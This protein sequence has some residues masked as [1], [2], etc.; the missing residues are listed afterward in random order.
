MAKTADEIL[1]EVR[2]GKYQYSS[3]NK[4]TESNKNKSVVDSNLSADEILENVRAGKYK[5]KFDYSKTQEEIANAKSEIYANKT[6]EKGAIS[7]IVNQRKNNKNLAEQAAEQTV[8]NESKAT[9]YE[10]MKAQAKEQK[11]TAGNEKLASILNLVSSNITGGDTSAAIKRYEESKEPYKKAK[12]DLNT[13]KKNKWDETQE[14]NAN[15]LA[16]NADLQALVAKASAAKEAFDNSQKTFQPDSILSHQNTVKYYEEYHNLAKQIDDLGY[17]ATSLVDTYTRQKNLEET[18]EYQKQAT[19]FA[20]KH[21][22][23]SSGAYVGANALQVG[24][25]P[26]ILEAGI[27]NIATDE[28]VPIDT[29]SSG[30]LATNVRNSIA[31]ENTSNITE[32][33]YEK[34]NSELAAETSA[35]LYQT[36]LSI[37]D[38][39]SAAWMPKSMSLAIMSSSA[40]ASTA[41]EAT[42]RGLSADKAML[43]AGISAAAEIIFEKYSIDGIKYLKTLGKSGIKNVAKDILKQSFTEGSEELFTEIS[44]VVADMVIN[45]DDSALMQQYQQLID[46]GISESDAK[47]QVAIEFAKQVGLAYLGG[48]ISGSF[49]GGGVSAV[50]T[51]KTNVDYAKEGKAIKQGGFAQDVVNEGLSQDTNSKAYQAAAII[52]KNNMIESENN[53]DDVIDFSG[54]S[55]KKLGKLQ[56]LNVKAVDTQNFSEAVADESNADSLVETF[57]KIA[58]GDVVS[59]ESANELMNNEVAR[60]ALQQITGYQIESGKNN[61]D[62]LKQLSAQYRANTRTTISNAPHESQ[63][64]TLNRINNNLAVST[65]KTA[66]INPQKLTKQLDRTVQLADNTEDTIAT[67]SSVENGKVF[68]ETSNGQV[69]DVADVSFS[70]PET[71]S[72]YKSA[73]AYTEPV[74]RA[75]VFAYGNGEYNTDL[76]DYMSGVNKVWQYQKQGYSLA[77]ATQLAQESSS[78]TEMQAKMIY[79]AASQ[80]G[81]IAKSNESKQKNETKNQSF[82]I[83]KKKSNTV[84]KFEKALNSNVKPGATVVAENLQPSQKAEVELINE[85]AK[86]INREIVIVS[87]LE[88]LGYGK[89]NGIYTKGKIVLPLNAD[90]G[91]MSVYLGHELF[92][93]LKQTAPKQADAL[94]KFIIDKL[95]NSPLYEY[96]KRVEEIIDNYKFKGTREQQVALANEEIAGN[97]C[98]T[99]LSEQANFEQLVKQDKSLAQKVR[100]FFADFIDK[101]KKALKTVAQTNKEYRALQGD[102]EAKEQ[103]L[104]MF[105]EALKASNNIKISSDI[106][107]YSVKEN[108]NA[109]VNDLLTV[110]RTNFDAIISNTVIYDI[111]SEVMIPGVK[112]SESIE[113]YFNSIGNVAFNKQIGTVELVKSG[114]KSTVAHGF[115]PDKASA[116]S[117]IKSVIENGIIID[118]QKNWKG[119]GYDTV[120][121]AGKGNIYGEK[122]IIGVVVKCYSDNKHTPKFYLHELV[123]I[124]EVDLQNQTAPQL[125]VDTVS[126]STS[127]NNVPQKD[128]AVNNYDMQDNVKNP[129]KDSEG[130]ELS[131]DQQEFFKNVAPELRD[132]NGNIKPFYHGTSRGDRVGYYF[133][134]EKATSGPMAYFTDNAEIA[135]NYSRNKA[136]TSLAYDNEYDSYETQFRVNVDGES[137]ALPELWYYLNGTQR[138]ELIR[139]I[140]QVTLDDDLEN[141]IIKPDNQYGIGNFSDNELRYHKGNALSLLIDGWLGGGTFFGEEHRFL[142]VLEAIGVKKVEYKDPNYREEKVYKTYLNITNP[143]DTKYA[144][145]EFIAD[146][147]DYVS[148]TDMS[149]YDKENMQADMWDKNGMPIDEWIEKLQWDIEEGTTHAWTVIPDVVTDFLKDYGKYDGIIDQGGKNGGDIH[150]VAIPFYSNQIKLTDN[151]NPTEDVD[152][153][154]SLKDSEGNALTEEQQKF[155]ADSK[156]RDEDGR[157]IPVYHGTFDDFTIFDIDKTSNINIYGKGH[158]FTN[159]KHDATKNYAS[160]DGGDVKRK[161]ESL[162]YLYFTEMG[163]TEEDSYDIEYI[164]EWNKAYDKAEL[165]YNS[166]KVLQVYLNMVNPV[167]ADKYTGL[168]D[169]DGEFVS[170]RSVEMLKKLGF[171]GIID[172]N[173]SHKFSEQKLDDDTVHYIVFDSNQI[174]LTDNLNPTEDVDIRYSRKERSFSNA[175][176]REEW[177][178]FYS[179]ISGDTNKNALLIGDNGVMVQ[180]KDDANKYKL[181]VYEPMEENIDV[182]AVY[183]LENYDYNIHDD[184]ENIAKNIV[185]WEKDG[186]NEISTKRLLQDYSLLYGTIFRK[187]NR[188]TR[189]FVKYARES[190]LLSKGSKQQSN[191]T[192]ISERAGEAGKYSRKEKPIDVDK[193]LEEN[194]ELSAMNEQLQEMLAIARKETTITGRHNMSRNSVDNVA[195]YFRRNYGST[196][197]KRSL[198]ARLDGLYDYIANAGVDIDNEYIWRTAKDIAIELLDATTYKDTTVYDQYADLRN[199]I[200]STAVIV[201]DEVKGDM[202]DYNEFRKHNF[203]RL[204]LVNDGGISLDTFYNELA[205]EYPE[206]FD[207]DAVLGDQLEALAN[208]FEITQPVYYN[209]AQQYAES[210]GLSLDE[211][212]NIVASDIF[213]KYFDVIETKTFAEKKQKELTDLKVKYQNR[214]VDIRK[215][216]R[217]DYEQ[218]LKAENAKNKL[219]VDKVRADKADALAKQKSHFKEVKQNATVRRKASELRRK[220]AN[221]KKRLDTKLLNPTETSYVPQGLVN[222]VAEICD[223]MNDADYY[224]AN[225]EMRSD[226]VVEKLNNLRSAYD[227]LKKDDSYEY[228]S[229]YDADLS[230]ELNMLISAIGLKQV[231]ELSVAQLEDV[232]AILS[233]IEGTI[234]DANKLIDMDEKISVREAGIKA[235]NEMEATKGKFRTAIGK[236]EMS[237]LTP[238]RAIEMMTEYNDDAQLKKMF[239]E[240]NNG[241]RKANKFRSDVSKPFDD[242]RHDV[243]NFNK[244]A[245]EEFEVP[246][247]TTAGKNLKLTEKQLVELIM[248]TKRKQAANHLQKGGFVIPDDKLMHKGERKNAIAKGQNVRSVSIDE[249]STL[250]DYLSDYGKRWMSFAETLFNEQS[251]QAI[252]ETSLKLKHRKIATVDKYIPITVKDTFVNKDVEGIKVDASIEGMGVLKS[253][254]PNANQPL[255]I[256]GIDSIIAKHI[257]SVS[258]YYGLAIPI[259]NFNKV[260]NVQTADNSVRESIL[261]KWGNEGL[262][263]IEDVI[264]DL[265]SMRITRGTED[266]VDTIGKKIERNIISATLLA[267]P[268]VAIKQLASYATTLGY[269]SSGSLTKASIDY[270]T[271]LNGQK[272]QELTDKIDKYTGTLY[273]RRIGMTT[274]EIGSLTKENALITRLPDWANR[275]NPMKWM[276]ATDIKTAM[277]LWVACENEIKHRH[278]Q[279]NQNSDEFGFKVAEFY[280]TVIE[281][282]QAVYDVMNRAGIM[283]KNDIFHRALTLFKTQNFH[284]TGMIYNSFNRMKVKR[285]EYKN[286]ANDETKAS[287]DA[288]KT[289]FVRTMLGQAIGAVTFVG[290]SLLCGMLKHGMSAYRD[291]DEE[292]T[293]E[294]IVQGF[295]VE[296]LSYV[297]EIFAPLLGDLIADKGIDIYALATDSNINNYS[298]DV[299]SLITLSSIND[300]VESYDTLT[301]TVDGYVDGEKSFSDVGDKFYTVVENGLMLAGIPAKTARQ[302]AT[303]IYANIKDLQNGELGSFEYGT[304][305]TKS[306]QINVI[307]KDLAKG[308]TSSYEKYADELYAS[309]KGYDLLY[310]LAKQY[311]VNSSKYQ[312]AVDRCIKVKQENGVDNPKPEES[313]KKKALKEYAELREDGTYQEAEQARQLCIALYG[314]MTKVENAL[315]ELNN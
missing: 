130:N 49:M 12:T 27:R 86:S 168:Y 136:D 208:V 233:Q 189:R 104:A 266:F 69:V 108:K 29:N 286:N 95:K 58:D 176:S 56:H 281:N 117:A 161:V 110:L 21:P 201:S 300:F 306:Q 249:I 125:S 250:Y 308:D 51:I 61:A 74:A 203:G 287:Y 23:L 127:N 46:N 207:A 97:A 156:V 41:K 111:N 83:G 126:K 160:I 212:A 31:E 35:F 288:A 14:Q 255:V 88:E 87:D 272:Y 79:S 187:Y 296:L 135:E 4:S 197:S 121:I 304:E 33:V 131:Q 157:L 106:T 185:M 259:R 210:E 143:F 151:L 119:R 202:A 80:D 114:A 246:I 71:A 312:S 180:D 152:I 144:D 48:S 204:R 85:F 194:E 235:I 262:G 174:K 242:L 291:E 166:G 129:L 215:S 99:V 132:E 165:S 263:M 34:T 227:L 32:S 199:R 77:D 293:L 73:S 109:N 64:D 45:G 169:K 13:L 20:S 264:A 182:E 184:N 311:G 150:T 191:R 63:Q 19:E 276:Q 232:Y 261:Q 301:E 101:I 54:V 76:A 72:L 146:L 25:V 179:S 222:A 142:E 122:S 10:S 24:A 289:A 5:D 93:D 78:I 245:T 159:S 133:D 229:E 190:K 253:T 211:Y 280:D 248:D 141:V 241:Q 282:T 206:M 153:R 196:Y 116:V 22:V 158:Y 26:E 120:V 310:E 260:F 37:G 62:T 9:D 164:D 60:N 270:V 66:Q 252:N 313:V 89:S 231:R 171:D 128:T 183:L 155:F 18:Q 299:L 243:I 192:G 309:N 298:D 105:D 226:S 163:Y 16:K 307:V 172:Y 123:K 214:I 170:A 38:F 84:E 43:T 247:K 181:V 28:Y 149:I 268:S 92:H 251:K 53:A 100:D 198:S 137:I 239:V 213:N 273:M 195:T 267:N 303:G 225:G 90:G 237:V 96:D 139:K 67:I 6:P 8:E 98:F 278:P 200:K 177:A 209:S 2:Q 82:K 154:Y 94:E 140:K 15:I 224:K 217:D 102:I 297:V 228:Q 271:L 175:L 112:V 216:Y 290:F 124:K 193:L 269:F 295:T 258:K 145:E 47:K 218:R 118:K 257:D 275:V 162:A 186:R 1:E 147:E 115:G 274:N 234:V 244:F 238:M 138:N 221:I 205:Q 178:R 103:I 40:A 148:A 39:A 107:Y 68:V 188:E 256:L 314:S 254:V 167:Y 294:S 240:L 59:P 223:I 30:F 52:A 3:T 285:A 17:D 219:K 230:E 302:Y 305:R 44:N 65:Q 315:K 236:Y 11:K 42:D 50:N 75:Y 55:N 283:K 173:V 284:N 36:G 292:V 91:M 134:P 57:V 81:L 7:N 113:S 70:N 220:I 265:Q 279:L 277:V